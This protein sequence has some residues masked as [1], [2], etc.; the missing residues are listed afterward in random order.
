MDRCPAQI[1]SLYSGSLE[2]CIWV[3]AAAPIN[4]AAAHSIRP[5]IS[6]SSANVMYYFL[7]VVS[8]DSTTLI[9]FSVSIS[10][11]CRADFINYWDSPGRHLTNLE[12]KK[13]I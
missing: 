6:C 2:E 12:K 5:V 11:L 7:K 3:I 13:K 4:T 10:I 9:I 1:L 8:A